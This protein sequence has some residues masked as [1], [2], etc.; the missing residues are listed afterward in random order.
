MKMHTKKYTGASNS[1]EEFNAWLDG[2]KAKG[3]IPEYIKATED[4]GYIYMEYDGSGGNTVVHP[5]ESTTVGTISMDGVDY[6]F[7]TFEF[8]LSDGTPEV[9]PMVTEISTQEFPSN[10]TVSKVIHLIADSLLESYPGFTIDKE[11]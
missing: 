10:E 3:D 5:G 7:V 9:V 11:A 2:L 8:S 4:S 1:L 6:S